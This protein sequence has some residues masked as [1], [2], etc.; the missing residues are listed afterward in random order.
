MDILDLLDRPIAF[1]RAFARLAGSVHAGLLLSQAVYWS[2]RTSDQAGWF[3]KTQVEWEEETCLSRREQESARAALRRLLVADQPLWYEERRGVPARIFYRI[4]F[5]VLQDLL[6]DQQYGE[7]RHSSMADSANLECTNPPNWN[8]GIRQ[9]ITENTYREYTENTPSFFDNRASRESKKK[10][11]GKFSF[12]FSMDSLSALF[13]EVE[14]AWLVENCPRVET[15]TASTAFL[16]YHRERATRFRSARALLAAWRGW[17]V[18]AEGRAGG[19][20][21]NSTAAQSGLNSADLE[22][23]RLAGIIE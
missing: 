15:Q 2:R 5:T 3:Y 12:D 7:K 17:M 6:S 11:G 21:K 18:R 8:G 20:P 19:T 4:D 13:T 9:T 22:S 23:L 14:H 10:N 16:N 1:H